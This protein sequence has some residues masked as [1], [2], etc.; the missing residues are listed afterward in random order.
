MKKIAYFGRFE[1]FKMLK[2]LVF[3]EHKVDYVADPANMEDGA[4]DIIIVGGVL[5][6]NNEVDVPELTALFQMIKESA[7]SI[8]IVFASIYR[9]D[10][11]WINDMLFDGTIDFYVDKET[12]SWITRLQSIADGIYHNKN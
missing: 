10:F 8:K 2:N 7:P 11:T 6:G 5:P 9:F 4:Y 12:D 3:T 1:S